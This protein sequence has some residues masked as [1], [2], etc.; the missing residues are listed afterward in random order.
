MTKR[1]FGLRTY[2]HSSAPIS[3]LELVLWVFTLIMAAAPVLALVS[4]W[5]DQ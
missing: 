3:R 4:L 2:I 1:H 5:I